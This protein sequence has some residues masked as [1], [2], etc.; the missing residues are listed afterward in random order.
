MIYFSTIF[1]ILMI[2]FFIILLSFKSCT[3]SSEEKKITGVPDALD[4]AFQFQNMDENFLHLSD[5]LQRKVMVD[6]DFDGQDDTLQVYQVIQLYD[7]YQG[8]G[9]LVQIVTPP[10]LVQSNDKTAVAGAEIKSAVDEVVVSPSLSP[11]T[12]TYDREGILSSA[13]E[14]AFS[15]F[16]QR[17]ASRG[18]AV[19]VGR[20]QAWNG[21]PGGD[22]C[23]SLMQLGEVD[24]QDFVK[25][26]VL[27]LPSYR[28]GDVICVEI[29][30]RSTLPQLPDVAK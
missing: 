28:K 9:T 26:N 12:K 18:I 1:M 21:K 16:G 5:F 2:L 11:E 3:G 8:K 22:D 30:A 14:D 13:L 15:E 7:Y 29:Y 17:Y 23:V 4:P 24:L 25:N 19:V 20:E 27:L 6:A 10:E